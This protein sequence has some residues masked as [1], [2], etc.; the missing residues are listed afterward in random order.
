MTTWTAILMAV[1]AFW[2][3]PYDIVIRGGRVLDPETGLDGMRNI[4]IR[5]GR[6][7]RVSEQP[8]A[9]IR[10][11]DAT[12]LV[13]APG[14]IDL[15]SHGQDAENYRLKALDGVTTALEMEIG[16][17]DVP[18]F[19][20]E[21]EGRALIHYGATASHPAARSAA[22]GSPLPTGTLLPPSG[23]ATNAPASQQQLDRMR[24]ILNREIDAGAL[25]LGMGLAY[26]P[27]ATRFEVLEMFRLAAARHLPVFTHVRSAGRT[28][29]GSSI[30]SM[31][32][33]IGASAVSGASLHV[34][35]INSTG[36]RDSQECL[37]MIEGARARGL[38]VTTEAYPYG[39]GMTAVNSALFNPGWREKLGIDYQDVQSVETGERLTA[40]SFQRLH[41]LTE[42]KYVLLFL[43]PE[44]IVDAVIEHPLVMIA[45]DGGLS[46]GKGHPRSSGTFARILSRYVRTRGSL[47]LLDAIR[48]MSY[49]PARRLEAATAQAARKG[50]LSEGADADLVVFDAAAITDRS[51][52]ERPAE[53]SVG[54]RFLL[55]AGTEVVREGQIV[56]KNFPGRALKSGS[57]QAP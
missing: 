45:S 50:R 41:A 49:L 6:I 42:P 1:V 30:E 4:G 57:G 21:R 54:V 44:E 12:G 16:V 25:G 7:A 37:R 48:K 46:G 20:R 33:V 35:H 15:H 17:A 32:E 34:V 13:V 14:F 9:G 5:E 38:D 47:T 27:G 36:L 11:I 8:L 2:Q 26:T 10:S 24:Q 3:S 31:S 23:T 43:N 51:T 39:A 52:Y 29:P 22:F 19:L 28:E 56:E 18:E 55:V 40:E 53:P